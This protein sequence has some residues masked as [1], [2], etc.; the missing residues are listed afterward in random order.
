LISDS[1]PGVV[2]SGVPLRTTSTT[3]FFPDLM[4]FLP[5]S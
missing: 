1:L 5:L 4:A 3:I 2:V